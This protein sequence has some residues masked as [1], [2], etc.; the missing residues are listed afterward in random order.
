MAA[1]IMS[2]GQITIVDLTDQRTSSFYLSANA[3]KIQ[4]Y[5]KST[6]NFSPD[7][8][9]NTVT[10][11]PAFFY[12]NQN[13]TD[14]LTTSNLT[15]AVNGAAVSQFNSSDDISKSKYAQVGNLLYI[16][17][18]I[19]SSETL[20]VVA[21]IKEEKVQDPETGLKNQKDIQ[22]NIEFARVDTGAD[23]TGIT[24]VTT[25]YG[26][27]ATQD[28]QLAE[29]EWK[30][31]INDVALGTT[32]KYL[33]IKQT[34]TFSNGDFKEQ[35]YIAGTY[36]E[37]GKTGAA[38]R[39]VKSITEEYYISDSNSSATGGS[40]SANA[41][42]SV[43]ANKYLW[44]R[45]EIVYT[46]SNG[47]PS[48]PE[49]IPSEGG[50]CDTTWKLAVDEVTAATNAVNN[51]QA[52]YDE[53]KKQVD[54]AIET[55]FGEVDPTLDGEPAS[56]WTT[57]EEKAKH[58]GDLYY[59][60]ATGRAWRYLYNTE[61]KTAEWIVVTDEGLSDALKQIDTLKDAVDDKVT[62]YYG[63][64]YPSSAEV[65][66][67]WIKGENGDSYRCTVAYKNDAATSITWKNYW[68]LANS[69]VRQIDIEFAKT[70]SAT[71][72]DENAVTWYTIS[73]TWEEGWYI[74]QRTHIKDGSN[75]TL[76]TSAPVC[77]TSAS[78][79]ITSVTNYYKR[80]T[81][82]SAPSTSGDDWATTPT[83]P[84]KDNPYLWNYEKVEYTYG[85]PSTTNPALI[86]MYSADGEAGRGIESITEYYL[87]SASGTGIT[88]EI[89]TN[90]DPTNTAWEDTV[91][92]TTDAAPYLWN[93]E[94]IKYNKAPLYEA[95]EPQVIGYRGVGV[96]SIITYYQVN[97]SNTAPD[98]TS[99]TNWKE[100]YEKAGAVSASAQYMWS[101]TKTTY[102]DNSVSNT[103][104]VII[105]TYAPAGK[106]AVY[107]VVESGSHIIFSDTQTQDITLTATLYVGGSEA[108][109]T[110]RVWSSIP[111]AISNSEKTLVVTRSM[112]TNIRT[113]ICTMTYDGKEYSD[114]ITISDKTDPVWYDIIS[115]NGDK[116]TNGNVSTTLTANLYHS[117]KGKLDNDALAKYYFNWKKY[118]GKGEEQ[119]FSPAT[120]G[121]GQAGYQNQ[122]TIGEKDVD[123]K[124]IFTCEVTTEAP[125][126]DA[127]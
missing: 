20:Y 69:A 26:V 107:V 51:L 76:S 10:V 48:A 86:G 71:S 57:A 94:V 36:G 47:E 27:S 29:N 95:S 77:I 122:I 34:T 58:N 3:S 84:N 21:T 9:T 90:G 5:D 96:K 11:T 89:D 33:W 126:T 123:S 108:T 66:D 103:N 100:T 93:A 85:D 64:K 110:K 49:Y 102:T 75:N 31:S 8:K 70:Q 116:F 62:I 44:T 63:E 112:V 52:S 115:S 39:S 56:E 87:I 81:T 55:H 22:A 109:P 124:A 104:P 111:G 61:T 12:G 42:T 46:E 6:G 53:L 13:C 37:T 117:Q 67:L 80:T 83:A 14:Q 43:E 114:R 91:Q 45:T 35:I 119:P 16:R 82:N 40:W 25:Q 121:A 99:L 59:N 127:T 17:E 50:K 125:S 92:A 1:T 72:I 4:V 101:F 118:N 41:P 73:P 60:T 30:N 78:R 18:N 113:F 23:G 120:S 74:W 79:S 105:A 54:D 65:N 38:G 24:N 106:D 28:A 15:Y 88:F 2:T 68:A 19:D 97:N 98:T 7:Y 32:N